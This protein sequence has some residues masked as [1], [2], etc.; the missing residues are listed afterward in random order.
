MSKKSKKKSKAKAGKAALP[1]V[2]PR[3]G[4]RSYRPPV[5]LNGDPIMHHHRFERI[6]GAL[7]SIRGAHRTLTQTNPIAARAVEVIVEHGVG[8]GVRCAFSG[9]YGY[10]SRFYRWSTTTECDYEGNQNL[11]GIQDLFAR[12]IVDAGE[13]IIIIRNGKAKDGYLPKLQVVDPD[14]L[15]ATATPQYHDNRVIQ[16]IEIRNSGAIVGYHFAFDSG[17]GNRWREFVHADHV[18][19][20]FERKWPGQLRGVPAGVQ[21]LSK[22]EALEAFIT[23]ALAK[24]R[25]ECCLGVA[26]VRKPT[27]DDGSANPLFESMISRQQADPDRETP[28]HLSPALIF[29]V[30]AGADVRTISPS[31]SGG[32]EAYIRINREDIATGYGVPYAFI[33]SDVGRA[34]F[35]SSKVALEAFYKRI[36]RFQ[37]NVLFPAF[38]N[39]ELAFRL[40]YELVEGVDLSHIDVTFIPPSRVSFEPMKD[41]AARAMRMKMRTLSWRQACYE[42]GL[43]PDVQYAE[44]KRE[45]AQFEKDGIVLAY[46]DFVVGA[47]KAAE[48]E[49]AQNL[50]EEAAS[51]TIDLTP[52]DPDE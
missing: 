32:Y 21:V 44:I 17:G 28:S 9:A 36:E 38:A 33:T 52:E 48:E 39:I 8:I 22:I 5:D 20:A 35:A 45:D 7:G 2:A 19:H 10:D 15:D 40:S 31:S 42:Q 50:A 47:K 51:R 11:A 6:P 46:D 43:D 26:V 30:E 37:H 49:E 27:F 13:G 16:G 41:M 4:A 14:L 25:I 23:A 1:A 34:N 18:I 29:D 12:S 24:A 3:K